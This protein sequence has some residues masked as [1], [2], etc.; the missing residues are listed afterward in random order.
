MIFVEN[1]LKFQLSTP[2]Y[3]LPVF[4][5]PVGELRLLQN[6]NIN[7]QILPISEFT[8]Y[9]KSEKIKLCTFRGRE[10]IKVCRILESIGFIFISTYNVVECYKEE[11]KEIKNESNYCISLASK[12]EF[13]R[14]IEIEGTVKDYSTFSIDPLISDDKSSKRNILRVKSHFKKDNHRIYVVRIKDTIAGF[15]QFKVDFVNKR[16]YTLNAAIHPDFQRMRIGK[17]LFSD[18]FKTM[19]DEGCEVIASDYSTQ[20][21][22]S[23]KLHQLCNF[24]IIDQEIHFRYFLNKN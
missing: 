15:I 19:F 1:N 16:A 4:G 22:G 5:F 9:L 3:E 8:N 12:E 24:K 18:S 23:A 7:E 6:S 10:D 17:T 20:N 2:Q 21:I 14:I 13:D 11:F